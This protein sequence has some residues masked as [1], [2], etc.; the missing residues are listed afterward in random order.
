M[1][2]DPQTRV[3]CV[4]DLL[5][6]SGAETGVQVAVVHDGDVVVDAV[7]GLADP[8]TQEPVTAGT[9]FLRCVDG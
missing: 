5:V 3:Q 7:A 6:T 8:H 1:V 4:I 9:L 2:V